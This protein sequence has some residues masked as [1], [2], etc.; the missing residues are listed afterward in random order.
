MEKMTLRAKLILRLKKEFKEKKLP[1]EKIE[2]LSQLA[3]N[4][5]PHH[6]RGGINSDFL[7]IDHCFTIDVA[8]IIAEYK[9]VTIYHC[10]LTDKMSLEFWNILEHKY[11]IIHIV[12]PSRVLKNGKKC[13]IYKRAPVT[14]TRNNGKKAKMFLDF[15]ID[16]KTYKYYRGSRK[17]R[18]FGWCFGYPES[19]IEMFCNKLKR[20]EWKV[21]KN[22]NELV[23]IK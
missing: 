13:I 10:N 12:V 11:N 7:I 15:F 4:L 3:S 20:S 23:H 22:N 1:N 18:F 8:L 21:R 5:T 17:F 16:D 19:D 2:I 14:S 6:N 9:E